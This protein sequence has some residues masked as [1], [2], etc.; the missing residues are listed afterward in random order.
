MANWGCMQFLVLHSYKQLHSEYKE[1]AYRLALG[2]CSPFLSL[3]FLFHNFNWIFHWLDISWI[4]PHMGALWLLPLWWL[5]IGQQQQQQFTSATLVKSKQQQHKLN[6]LKNC[7]RSTAIVPFGS[8]WVLP[9]KSVKITHTWDPW[10]SFQIW[11]WPVTL[12]RILHPDPIGS[13]S[14][15]RLLG[16]RWIH[17]DL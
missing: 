1:A 12:F 15:S 3:N 7:F 8:V 13:R 9:D 6:I 10:Q 4:L 11:T 16:Y 14:G 2:R 17:E 5:T